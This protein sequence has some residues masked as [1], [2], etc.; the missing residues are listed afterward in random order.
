MIQNLDFCPG[1]FKKFLVPHPAQFAGKCAA[2][3]TEEVGKFGAA[4]QQMITPFAVRCQRLQVDFQPIPQALLGKD[5]HLCIEEQKLLRHVLHQISRYL[6]PAGAGHG[7]LG[8]ECAEIQPEHR[9]VRV[10][11]QADR[12]GTPACTS[13]FRSEDLPACQPAD[14]DLIAIFIVQKL[15][16]R[17]IQQDTGVMALLSQFHKMCIAGILM[18]TCVQ[19]VQNIPVAA[20][21]DAVEHSALL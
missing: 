12:T 20:R 21:L 11:P 1:K 13:Q 4:V 19:A 3:Y 18:H 14:A 5:A 15:F 2:V 10:G 7:L 6:H 17:A 8:H 16:H 9:T